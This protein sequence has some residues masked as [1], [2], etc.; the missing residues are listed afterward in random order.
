MCKFTEYFVNSYFID[1]AIGAPW[2]GKDGKGVVFLYYGNA[3]KEKPLSL[4][5]V[6]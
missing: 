6:R 4:K 5:Q 1:I 3:D 2:G